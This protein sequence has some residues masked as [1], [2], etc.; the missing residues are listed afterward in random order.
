MRRLPNLPLVIAALI[1]VLAM[2]AAA[3]AVLLPG[4]PAAE[5]SR[6]EAEG[7]VDDLAQPPADAEAPVPAP[8]KRPRRLWRTVIEWSLYVGFVVAAV[9]LTPRLLA[10]ALDTQYPLAAVTSSSMW[11]ALHKGDMVVLQGVDKPSD[12]KVGD[13]IGFKQED[14]GFAIHRI[15]KIDGDRITTKGDANREPD[16]VI[17]FDSVV[18]RVPKA[19][20]VQAKVRYLGYIGILLGPVFSRSASDAAPTFEGAPQEGAGVSPSAGSSAGSPP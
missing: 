16:P 11:P 3:C 2:A 5:P 17:T 18:G 12:L 9:V 15:V 13:I 1:G 7:S 14:G 6:P 10:K 20:G 19:V 4:P 8:A